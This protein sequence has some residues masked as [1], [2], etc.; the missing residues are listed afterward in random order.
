M[1][2]LAFMAIGF[3]AFSCTNKEIITIKVSDDSANAENF[4][5]TIEAPGLSDESIELLAS[6]NKPLYSGNLEGGSLSVTLPDV[7]AQQNAIKIGTYEIPV[8]YFHTGEATE[9]VYGLDSLDLISA[10]GPFQ[11]SILAMRERSK[12]FTATMDSL[13]V[14]YKDAMAVGDEARI[15]GISQ[16]ARAIYEENDKKNV[17]FAKRNNI[18]GA[19]IILSVN[20]SS[21][22]NNDYVEVMNQVDEKY[23]DA[24][25]YLRL[26]E[27]LEQIARVAPGAPFIDFS[28][29][30]PEGDELSI[31]S[32]E[33]KYILV[34]FWAS[35]CKPCRAA[36]PA[37]VETYE[38]YHSKGFNIIGVSLDRSREDWITGIEEDGLEWP[39][40]SDLKFWENEVAVYYGIRFIP[41]NL[42]ID[43][44][45]VIVEHNMDEASLNAFLE[46]NL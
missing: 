8:V 12:V 34:D 23:H 41:Q 5:L 44:N 38:K 10:T 26:K 24:P 31:L 15:A 32:V 20:E 4:T 17:A 11:D 22:D 14:L 19:S 1:R 21:L 7:P 45:G 39:Q 29:A 42:L 9:L 40:I 36:N 46:A 28:Q 27:K 30:T 33:G 3:M 6:G 43:G 37:L 2:K 25:D 35:W 13:T 18:L 16:F